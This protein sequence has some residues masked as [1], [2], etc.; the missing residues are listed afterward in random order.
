MERKVIIVLG[1]SLIILILYTQTVTIRLSRHELGGLSS[2]QAA[3]LNKAASVQEK[4]AILE[5]SL[6]EMRATIQQLQTSMQQL[7]TRV[8]ALN[9]ELKSM[10]YDMKA[11][12]GGLQQSHKDITRITAAPVWNVYSLDMSLV[13]ILSLLL[14]WLMYRWYM[15]H[16]RSVSDA[17]G[18]KLELKVLEGRKEQAGP[19]SAG[20]KQRKKA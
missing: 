19:A 4:R 5:R 3:L 2:Q 7:Q 8:S 16:R 20:M 12:E 14:L 1:A 6:T 11:V 18:Q 17:S 10:E 9:K 13:L 15:E